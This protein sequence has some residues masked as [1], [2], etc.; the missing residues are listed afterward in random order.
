MKQGP[1]TGWRPGDTLR[2]TAPIHCISKPHD[3]LQP[4][5]LVTLGGFQR[6][7]DGVEC[8]VVHQ[9]PRSW[10]ACHPSLEP[11]IGPVRWLSCFY[12]DSL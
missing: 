1:V 2:V 4:G 5:T 6:V 9:G 8:W 7:Q 10:G 11:G 12:I 3:V